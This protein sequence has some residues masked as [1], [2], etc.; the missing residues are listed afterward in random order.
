MF[1]V[2][3]KIP[4]CLSFFMIPFFPQFVWS[5]NYLV[6]TLWSIKNCVNGSCSYSQENKLCA[7][8]TFECLFTV[9][10]ALSGVLFLWRKGILGKGVKGCME[11]VVFLVSG[12]VQRKRVWVSKEML[13]FFLSPLQ[14]PSE[15]D[16]LD[17]IIDI[18]SVKYGVCMHSWI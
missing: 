15:L 18:F 11:S 14:N 17:Y 4:R 10:K 6:Y 3:I 1:Q 12:R 8:I 5:A 2:K 7:K 9:S 16:Y 13:R